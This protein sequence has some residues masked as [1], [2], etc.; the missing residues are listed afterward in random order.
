[1]IDEG[2]T[3]EWPPEVIEAADRFQQG[4]LIEKPPIAYAADLRF[5]VWSLSRLEAGGAGPGG[6]AADLAYLGLHADDRPP[7][8]I[9]IEQTC[10][11]AE[12]RP[13]PLMPWFEVAPVY[14]CDESDPLLGR[15]FIYPLSS[16]P[17]PE[18]RCW[19]ADLR[20]R[21]PLEKGVLVGRGPIDPF[22]GDEQ[23]RIDF[24]VALGKRISR[25]ALAESVHVVI[26][27]T[28]NT[29]KRNTGKRVG[30]RVYK[31]MIQVEEGTRLKPQ[32]VRLHVLSRESPDA[33]IDDDGM[34]EWFASWESATREIAEQQGINLLATEFHDA[35]AMDLT[36]YDR[37]VEIR[38]PL[39]H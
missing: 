4:D 17:A 39:H 33:K 32:S 23:Q 21:P 28:I 37:L 14:E 18:K 29:H 3:E 8:G 35:A 11:V 20:L 7:F 25:A 30:T 12:D 31:L 34:K 22:D 24:G 19:V 38:C 10:D 6:E 5:A 16:F 1:M 13:A 26:E 9:I 15:D 2:L 27:D 36:L